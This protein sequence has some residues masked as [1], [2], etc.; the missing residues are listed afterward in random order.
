[1][2]LLLIL[3]LCYLDLQYFSSNRQVELTTDILVVF[4]GNASFNCILVSSSTFIGLHYLIKN[5]GWNGH[6][7]WE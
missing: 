5:I 2:W 6:D 4:R 3:S 1:M 7:K